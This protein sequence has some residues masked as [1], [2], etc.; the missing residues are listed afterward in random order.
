VRPDTVRRTHHL[1]SWISTASCEH[2]KIFDLPSAI[3]RPLGSTSVNVQF[4]SVGRP[5]L[6]PGTLGLK[7]IFHRL[8]C[9][10]LVAYVHC[11]QEN[12]LF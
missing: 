8:F 3:P 5:G 10:G 11:F 7:G 1:Q 4:C 9:V 2:S 6:D 12:V